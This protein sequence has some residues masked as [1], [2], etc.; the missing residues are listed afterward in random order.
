MRHWASLLLL[1]PLAAC[2]GPAPSSPDPAKLLQQSAR[3]MSSVHSLSADVKFSP[4]VMYQGFALASAHTDISLPGASDT[5]LKVKQQDFLVDVR[6]VSVGDQVYLKV[7]FGKFTQVSAAQVSEIPNLAGLF[8]AQK[9]LPALLA[10]GRNPQ[11]QGS[12]K[13]GSV[14]CDKVTATYTADQVAGLLAGAKPPG[15]VK[16][17]LWIGKDDHRLYRVLLAGPLFEAGQENRVDI[18]IHDYD[19]PLTIVQPTP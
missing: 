14:D 16:A 11:Y 19:R 2:S 10:Q 1:L 12:E 13:A 4:E 9:G 15:D 5:T 18:S 17:T 6:V 3:A 7:P 8:D